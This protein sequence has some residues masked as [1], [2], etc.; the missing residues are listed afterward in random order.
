MLL[1]ECEDSDSHYF[2]VQELKRSGSD[3]SSCLGALGSTNGFI[4]AASMNKP[5]FILRIA[6]KRTTVGLIIAVSCGQD[7]FLYFNHKQQKYQPVREIKLWLLKR[8]MEGG[9]AEKWERT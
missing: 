8:K 7:F 5:S 9:G 2:L 1:S 4:K 3:C 6:S